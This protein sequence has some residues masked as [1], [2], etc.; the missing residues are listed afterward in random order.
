M[1][2][3][4]GLIK[5][6]ALRTSAVSRPSI[7]PTTEAPLT[8]VTPV[9]PLAGLRH[10]APGAAQPV[11]PPSAAP[12]AAPVSV[13]VAELERLKEAARQEGRSQGLQQG[14]AEA[15]KALHDKLGELNRLMASLTQ[16]VQTHCQRQE[17]QIV[18]FAFIAANR[19]LGNALQDRAAVVAGV[20]AALR[21]S[22][23]WQEATLELHPRDLETVNLA[24]GQ[25]SDI[26]FQ[27]LRCVASALVTL[28][29]CRVVTPEGVLDARL[30]VQ[31]AQLHARL[32]AARDT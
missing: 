31:L 6:A 8:P 32:Q 20:K 25:E 10:N 9:T 11:L 12:T 17:D 3:S 22:Q 24:L 5:G 28:G 29:G 7:A 26:E 19:V 15:E 27:N 4:K 23:P 30:E 14:K 2:I 21:A 1:T 16:A 18:D 13:N